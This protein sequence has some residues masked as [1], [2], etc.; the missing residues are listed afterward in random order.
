MAAAEECEGFTVIGS[1]FGGGGMPGSDGAGKKVRRFISRASGCT[2]RL[3]FNH[4]ERLM[5]RTRWYAVTGDAVRCRP[6][7]H[8]HRSLPREGGLQRVRR[9]RKPEICESPRHA[10]RFR[11]RFRVSTAEGLKGDTWVQIG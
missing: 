5:Q 9:R 6:P 11:L 3:H 10:R 2:A 4:P 8:L 7:R 1:N